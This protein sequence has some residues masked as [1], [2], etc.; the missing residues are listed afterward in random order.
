MAKPDN[1]T[2]ILERTSNEALLR[3]F[4]ALTHRIHAASRKKDREHEMELRGQRGKVEAEILRR[5]VP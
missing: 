1:V 4:A 5:M 3:S 2:H